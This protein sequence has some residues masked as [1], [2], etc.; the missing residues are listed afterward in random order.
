MN[1]GDDTRRPTTIIKM[2]KIKL[3]ILMVI[4]IHISSA[5]VIDFYNSKLDC[6]TAYTTLEL[7]W[8]SKYMM[9]KSEKTMDS[10]TSVFLSCLDTLLRDEN[11]YRAEQKMEDPNVSFEFWTDYK[12]T[13][14]MFTSS[15]LRFKE[16]A[17]LERN[18]QGELM[19]TGREKSINENLTLV[20]LYNRRIEEISGLIEQHC[21]F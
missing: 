17:E 8:C 21:N 12:K 6:D 2:I 18:I 13:K 16:F 9:K 4:S 19:G 3:I 14:E 5:Q 10:L 15:Q 1:C 7:G 20:A 11:Q